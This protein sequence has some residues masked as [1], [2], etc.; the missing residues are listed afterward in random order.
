MI[1]LLTFLSLLLDSDDILEDG[2]GTGFGVFFII[3][4]VVIIVIIKNV[5]KKKNVG[6]LNTDS[7]A[8]TNINFDNLHKKKEETYCEYCGGMIPED[9]SECPYC[10]AKR[11]KK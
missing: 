10:G 6:K 11:K 4:I 1:N 5:K 9:K 2:E 8:H 7:S 3:L